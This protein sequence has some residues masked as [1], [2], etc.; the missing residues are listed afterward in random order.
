[1]LGILLEILPAGFLSA[2][3][4]IQIMIMLIK[5]YQKRISLVPFCYFIQSLHSVHK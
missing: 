2:K 1:M 3:K 5:T 4:E